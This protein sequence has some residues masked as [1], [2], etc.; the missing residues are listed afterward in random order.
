MSE[1]LYP[2]NLPQLL[3]CRYQLSVSLG[4][5]NLYPITS[6]YTAQPVA[7]GVR[8]RGPCGIT[9]GYAGY[10]TNQAQYSSIHLLSL[11]C[12]VSLSLSLSNLSLGTVHSQHV[13]A[14][15]LQA[16]VSIQYAASSTPCTA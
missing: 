9:V 16:G 7:A 1:N 3:P 14:T 15:H 6:Y 10:K 5:A 13:V 2:R 8:R 11:N 4:I 12:L